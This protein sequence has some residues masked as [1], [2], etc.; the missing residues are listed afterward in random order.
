MRRHEIITVRGAWRSIVGPVPRRA[1]RRHRNRGGGDASQH[2]GAGRSPRCALVRLERRRGAGERGEGLGGRFLIGRA[3]LEDRGN[4]FQRQLFPRAGRGN[5]IMVCEAQRPSSIPTS[6]LLIGGGT[7]IK[8]TG[9]SANS[10]GIPS[11]ITAFLSMRFQSGTAIW[12]NPISTCRFRL[13]F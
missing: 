2:A 10:L 7:R 3:K 1:F 13:A 9:M 6:S 5:Q 8:T 11:G 4:V 12:A